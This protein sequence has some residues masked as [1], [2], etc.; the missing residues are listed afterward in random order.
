M[1]RFSFKLSSKKEITQF[2]W[3]KLGREYTDKAWFELTDHKEDQ[4]RSLTLSKKI[5]GSLTL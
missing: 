2:F 1:Q 3:V 4:M 5:M